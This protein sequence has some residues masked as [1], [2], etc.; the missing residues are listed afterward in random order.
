MA[1][2][3]SLTDK[4]YPGILLSRARELRDQYLQSLF[5]DV[6][7]WWMKQSLDREYGGYY[8]H[9]ER[10]GTPFTTD[11][12]M[13][14]L[15]RQVWMLSHLYNTYEMRPEWLEA[16]RLGIDFILDHGFR[17]N[18]KIYFRLTRDGRNRAEVL[19]TFSEVFVSIALA[20]YSKATN[21]KLIWNRAVSIY[22]HLIPKL[23]QAQ[24]TPMLAYPINTKVH[25]HSHDICR[26]TAAWVF[27][28]ID[29][30]SR[31]LDD[32]ELSVN[33]IIQRHWKPELGS[34]PARGVLL[35][36]VAM[37]GSP[38]LDILECRMFHP[39]H[40]IESAWMIMEVALKRNDAKLF[41]TAVDIMMAAIEH[42][43]D[44]KYGGI[45]YL[46][47]YDWTPTHDLGADLKLWWPHT[48][49]LY[50]LLLAWVY[51][52]REEVKK[53]Y[54]LV[55]Q[56]TFEHF[57][58]PENGEWFGYLNRDG[59]PVWTA[60]GNGWKG[61]FHLPR[62]LYRCYKLLDSLVTDTY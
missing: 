3:I 56:Y 14:M 25:L 31:F 30:G 42:A 54:E 8:S 49:S 27:N 12:Y 36:N 39:G 24:D 52:G 62:A 28:E 5:E 7:P 45:R 16:A 4:R 55:H 18:G 2:M 43:W 37:D 61:C 29:P 35:E 41:H 58:D 51:T 33:S 59:S 34:G 48:E 26:I 1:K 6:I 13:W 9:L 10:D 38:L 46:T 17:D 20:E 40:S 21:D 50:A 22:D 57:P 53:W 23:G 44:Q 32:L 15:G 11:K 60:K 47:N 19:N